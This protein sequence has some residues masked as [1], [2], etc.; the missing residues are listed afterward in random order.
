MILRLYID[1]GVN[2]H[3]CAL[4]DGLQLAQVALIAP[5]AFLAYPHAHQ[6]HELVI[7]KMEVYPGAQQ[8]DP[9]DLIDVHG[10]AKTA[11]AFIRARG[12]PVAVWPKPKDWKGQIKKW[13]HHARVWSV[14]SP[15]ERETFARDSGHTVDAVGKKIDEACERWAQGDVNRRGK[16]RG[17]EWS[18]HNLLDA[19]GLGLWHLGRTGRAGHRFST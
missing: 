17:Y 15:A 10:A 3:A 9:N 19:V 16:V 6:L 14:L 18:A 5:D 2:F 7:E 4:F 13:Q 8:E 1:P 11:E 12:G